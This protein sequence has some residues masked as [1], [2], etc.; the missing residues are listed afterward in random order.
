MQAVRKVGRHLLQVRPREVLRSDLGPIRHVEVLV[1]PGK[2]DIGPPK[3][4]V[5]KRIAPHERA[6]GKLRMGGLIE[7]AAVIAQLKAA[8]AGAGA[9]GNKTAPDVFGD[10][11]RDL[12]IAIRHMGRIAEPHRRCG[13]QQHG[14]QTAKDTARGSRWRSHDVTE[15]DHAQLGKH[16][17][18]ER[19]ERLF[20]EG[21]LLRFQIVEQRRHTSPPQTRTTRLVPNR[22]AGEPSIHCFRVPREACPMGCLG[23]GSFQPIAAETTRP[24]TLRSCAL[25]ES[26]G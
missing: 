3:A 18:I 9:P 2:R 21:R 26:M 25:F 17:R 23:T 6:R 15:I 11:A 4:D 7:H 20:V 1:P 13:G 12:I 8:K 16:C 5:R 19:S 24:F 22:E 10:K 14:R